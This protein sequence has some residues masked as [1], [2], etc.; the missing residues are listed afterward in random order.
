[1]RLVHPSGPTNSPPL[2]IVGEAPGQ[3]E[4]AH[5]APFIGSSGKLLTQMLTA[6][7]VPRNQCYLTNVMQNRPPGN[8]FGAFYDDGSKRRIPSESLIAGRSRL[9]KELDEVKPKV[10]V[11]VGV[12]ALRAV[13]DTASLRNYRGTMIELYGRRI[14]P[15]YHPAYVLRDYGMRPVVECDLRKAYRQARH[16]SKPVVHINHVPSFSEIMRFLSERPEEVSVDIETVDQLTRCIGIGYS[17]SEAII[18][19]LTCRAGNLWSE[20]EETEIL[21]ALRDFLACPHIRKYLQNFPYDTTILERELGL[22]IENIYLDTMFA[23]HTMYPELLKS[24]SFLC[25]MYT[26]HHM[27]WD[28][29]SQDDAETQLYC[30]YDCLVTFECAKIFEKELRE[31]NLWEFYRTVV[32]PTVPALTRMQNRGVLIDV[33]MRDRLEVETQAEMKVLK[34]RI[35]SPVGFKLNPSSPK[36]LIELLYDKWKLP[37]QVHHKTRKVSTDADSLRVLSRKFPERYEIIRDIVTYREKRTLLGTF[38]RARLSPTSRIHTSY[39]VA[40]T[41]TG[42][43]S[44]SKTTDGLGGNLQNVPRGQFRRIYHADPG[45]VFIKADLSQAEYRVLIWSAPVPRIIKRILHEKGFNIHMW[46]ASKNIYQ[47]PESQVTAEQYSKAKNGVFGANYGVGAL[48]VSKMYDMEFRDA[49]FIIE[50]YHAAVPEIKDVYQ[51]KIREEIQRTRKLTN[52]LGRERM[53]FG[54]MDDQLFRAAYSHY[55]QSTV[56]D[57]ISLGIQELDELEFELL[58]QVHDEVVLQC[59]EKDVEATARAVKMA[60][61]RSLKFDGVQ[62]P[63]IIPVEIKVGPNWYDMEKLELEVA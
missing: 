13:A 40:G 39:N 58:L 17:N 5:G 42:R 43:I 20:S 10:I 12:E 38:I 62:E 34:D 50:R 61:E 37:R 63:L 23:H 55:C 56:A 25:S 7:G 30:G 6:A 4:V 52:P 15:T 21:L 53:F 59:P 14:L 27:Y 11:P 44:S 22:H 2:A 28:Y 35:Q 18:I 51:A 19:P 47:I 33:E 29:D 9:L 46:N 49:K 54:R 3:E 31:R 41:V 48:K 8:D 16:P 60:L 45:K 32:H 26:D 36:Q 57:L 1:M 24:L